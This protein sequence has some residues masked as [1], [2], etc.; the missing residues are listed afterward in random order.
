MHQ[1]LFVVNRIRLYSLE[2]EC[3]GT[4]TSS[5]DGG[6]IYSNPPVLP[7]PNICICVCDMYIHVRVCVCVCVCVKIGIYETL[8]CKRDL[9]V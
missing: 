7:L 5:Q 8:F 4:H 6:I 1:I 3:S 9:L 2:N